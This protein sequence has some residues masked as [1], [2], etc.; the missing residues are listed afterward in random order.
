MPTA[1]DA[2]MI[3][4]EATATIFASRTFFGSGVSPAARA[5]RAFTTITT[6]QTKKKRAIRAT[7]LN[8]SSAWQAATPVVHDRPGEGYRPS[9]FPSVAVLLTKPDWQRVVGTRLTRC[10]Q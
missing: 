9:S 8:T 1:N 10:G 7:V 2:P 6:D 5:L 3:T 4:T